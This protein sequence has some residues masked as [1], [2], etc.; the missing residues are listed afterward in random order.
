MKMLFCAVVCLL[1]SFATAATLPKE[2]R[3]PG[4]VAIVPLGKAANAPT[5]MFGDYR[6]AVAPR[7]D[8]WVAIVGIPLSVKPGMQRLRVTESD[9][10]RTVTFAVKD[11]RYR[12]Q[13]LKIEND[14]Q[15]NPTAEDLERIDG[16]RTRI[17]AALSAHSATDAPTFALRSPVNGTR[18]DSFGFR[19]VFNGEPRNPHS[20]MD[21]A[22]PTGTPIRS[23]AAGTVIEIGD[24]FFNG[25]SVFVDHGAGLVTMYC[26]LSKI[27][28]RTGDR[29]ATGDL[30]GEVG[31]TGRVTGPH[32]HF[33]VALNRAMVD[34]ALLLQP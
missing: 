11:K 4:G 3:T 28:V 7:E 25:N 16:E 33:G 10:E 32:L 27:A 14:R 21:I 26:H 23:P 22:A 31:A 24:F 19:R 30:L 6:V 13:H 9:K 17:E 29:L 18:S 20:G 34:P 1:W 5:V 15:V 2:Q 8:G 12:T